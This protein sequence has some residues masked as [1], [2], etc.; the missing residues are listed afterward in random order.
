MIRIAIVDDDTTDAETLENI[1]KKYEKEHSNVNFYIKKFSTAIAFLDKYQPFDIVFMDIE[2]PLMNGLEACR[3]IREKD[4]NVIIVFVTNI[5]QY[6]VDGYAVNA[7]DCIIKPVNFETFKYKMDRVMQKLKYSKDDNIVLKTAKGIINLSINSILYIESMEHN[8]IYHTLHGDF[9]TRDTMQNVIENI[10]DSRFV[11][12]N[13]CYL[14]NLKFVSEIR[15]WS[16]IVG[17]D[18]LQMSHLKK[19]EFVNE[20]NRYLSLRGKNS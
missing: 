17:G 20:V 2:M 14:V 5:V 7:F 8:I 4:N 10:N 16:A 1:L 19:K 6:A 18:E 3:N 12:C 11:L 9:Q 15:Q 13:R